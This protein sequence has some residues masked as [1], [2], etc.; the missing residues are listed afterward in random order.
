MWKAFAE[1]EALGWIDA[2]R[3]RPRMVAVQAEGCAPIVD[4]LQRGAETATPWQ[5][6]H[7]IASGIRV[8]AAVGDFLMLRA[9]RESGGTALT[10][11]DAELVEGT[12]LAASTEGLFVCPEAGAV[13]AGLRKLVQRGWVQPDERVVVFNTG[14]GLKYPE[15]FP[16]ELPVLDPSAPVD[17]A[18]L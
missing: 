16:V 9:I 17:Y 5:N 1:L 2:S 10:V 14:T 4:A 3:P 11:S 18:A 15:C 7:T 13:I 12:E 6:A 8:P